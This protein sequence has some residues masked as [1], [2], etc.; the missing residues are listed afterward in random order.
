MKRLVAYWEITSSAKELEIVR[1]SCIH[2][3]SPTLPDCDK[4]TA[5]TIK[6]TSVTGMAGSGPYIHDNLASAATQLTKYA[7]PCPDM[8]IM[9]RCVE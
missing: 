1:R 3:N 8:E 7:Q 6:T 4:S 9:S 2:E 5:S